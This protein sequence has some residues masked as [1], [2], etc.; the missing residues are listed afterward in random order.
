MAEVDPKNA[1]YPITVLI[2]ELKSEDRKKRVNAVQSLSSIGIAL[3]KERTRNEFLPY[4]MELMD[5]EEEVLIELATQLDSRFL[6]HIGGPLFASFLFKPLE[7]LCE[8]EE[9]TVRTRAVESIKNI[10]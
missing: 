7:R 2:D 1:L 8:V 9:I 3:G 4:I 10:L 5:D 6:D